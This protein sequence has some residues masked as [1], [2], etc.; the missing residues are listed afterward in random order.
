MHNDYA[1][2]LL[3][4]R[5]STK[6]FYLLAS[7]IAGSFLIACS[8]DMED[9]IDG[10]QIL[11]TNPVVAAEDA[12]LV[13][14]DITV[15]ATNQDIWAY[16]SFKEGKIINIE[17]PASSKDWD[18]GFQRT[19]IKVNGG[20]SGPGDGG[21]LM[22]TETKFDSVKQA[23]AGDYEIDT[24]ETLAIV[25]Q[26]KKGWYIYTGVPTHWILPIEDRVFVIKTAVGNFAKVQFIGYYKDNKNKKNPAFITYKYVYQ[27]DGDRNF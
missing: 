25:P 13:P 16:F 26:S 15:D 24:K 19:K 23:P 17:D 6:C 8:T 27:T 21:V 1:V 7:V 22:L 18:L 2:S 5:Y 12:I 11:T 9:E 4:Y 3:A 20:I 10:D 14:A